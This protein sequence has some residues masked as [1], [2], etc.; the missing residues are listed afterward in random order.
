MVFDSIKRIGR[1]LP[2]KY[3]DR[4]ISWINE[5][6]SSELAE[7][8]YA[9]AG[10]DVFVRVLSYKTKK[11]EECRIE[12]HNRYVDIQSTISGEEGI[13]IYKREMLE[14]EYAYSEKKDVVF[15]RKTAD[16]SAKIN[17]TEGTFAMLFPDE[18]H[19]PEISFNGE[20]PFIK[21]FVI[22]IRE[23]LYE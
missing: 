9:I 5:N 18:A 3:C 6:I 8:E 10:E 11:E 22:K 23:E 12:A 4:I 14:T 1:Y 21:K 16:P 19:Q 2:E 13:Q 7:G 17:V 20:C 15:F